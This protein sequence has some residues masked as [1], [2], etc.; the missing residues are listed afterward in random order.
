[1][2]LTVELPDPGARRLKSASEL[3]H[4]DLKAENTK[5]SPH[6]VAPRNHE[7]AELKGRM[8]NATLK[9]QSWNVFVLE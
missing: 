3:H 6:A 4:K 5:G 8:L 7:S 9:R 1:M 2:S